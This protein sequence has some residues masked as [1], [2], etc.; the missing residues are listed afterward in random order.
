M[1]SQEL[2]A[3]RL[4]ELQGEILVYD[5]KVQSLLGQ[6]AQDI[7]EIGR[8]LVEAKQLV[9]NGKWQEW[10]KENL[11]YSER[12][13]QK[14]MEFYDHYE[15]RRQ[16]QSLF[17][18][19]GITEKVLAL[20][21]SKAVA[22]MVLDDEEKEEFLQEHPDAGD[23]SV[24]KLQEA[25][26][27]KQQAEKLAKQEATA[28]AEAEN[29]VR[30]KDKELQDLRYQLN[31]TKQQVE[32]QQSLL[33]R[34]ETAEAEEKR[35]QEQLDVQK[36]KV[37]RLEKQIK[38]LQQRPVEVAPQPPTQEQLEQFRQEA[39]QAVQERL[40]QAEKKVQVA[41]ISADIE[42]FQGIFLETMDR[43]EEIPDKKIRVQLVGGIRKILGSM[44]KRLDEV[45]D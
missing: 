41:G 43:I 30:S 19:E 20:G 22:M 6:C 10:M 27:E 26:R 1:E 9:P 21:Y 40:Q 17:V 28:R 14:I 35:K 8:R 7:L 2:Q 24:R 3:A 16:Q 32:D 4:V 44:G 34:A 39:E 38:E 37:I 42:T 33:E 36:D 31:Q 25:I 15:K 11:Q 18:Q 45:E 5:H 13:A 12:K 23:M 29:Q